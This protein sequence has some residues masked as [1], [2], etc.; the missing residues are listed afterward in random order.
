MPSTGRT[1]LEAAHASSRRATRWSAADVRAI[2]MPGAGIAHLWLVAA[3]DADLAADW[4]TLDAD[5]RRRADRFR[6]AQDRALFVA[7]HAALRRVL[8]GCLGVDGRDLG[9]VVDAG[10]KPRLAG[11]SHPGFS[12]SH[13]GGHALIGVARD[14]AIG[15]D[16][17]IVRDVPERDAIVRDDFARAEVEAI[18]ALPPD[19]REDAFF[20]CWTRKEA[21]L[22]AIG[23]GLAG[24]LDSVEPGVDPDADAR[25]TKIGGDRGAAARWS[26]WSA[27]GPAG[28]WAA[29]AADRPAVAFHKLRH[30]PEPP[31][32]G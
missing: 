2:G 15:V 7:A 10:G 20:A 28:Y 23:V 22:K 26:L 6:F 27:A 30:V 12:L 24:G 5:E 21:C 11:R 4:S 18:A 29:A 32:Q 9:F 17:E 19:R 16:L 25:L 14:G 1:A 31:R 8:G 13:S 3:A